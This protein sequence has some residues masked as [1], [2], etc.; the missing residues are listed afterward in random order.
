MNKIY[1]KG[2]FLFVSLLVISSL[3]F[4]VA[5]IGYGGEMGRVP[6]LIGSGCV[7]LSI[8]LLVSEINPKLEKVLRIEGLDLVKGTETGSEKGKELNMAKLYTMLAWLGGLVILIIFVGFLIATGIF[9]F[10]FL[11]LFSNIS[12]LKSLLITIIAWGFIF[13]LFGVLLRSNLFEGIL[14]GAIPPIL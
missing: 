8:L 3:S 9:L 13:L 2:S 5:S 4:V 1:R 10:L 11:K 12:W 7:I 14:F 6:L